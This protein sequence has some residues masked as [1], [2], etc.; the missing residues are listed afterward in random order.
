[1]KFCTHLR[2]LDLCHVRFI[3]TDFKNLGEIRGP[4]HY[5]RFDGF[6]VEALAERCIRLRELQI[7][8]MPCDGAEEMF[9]VLGPSLK[10]L[11]IEESLMTFDT[12]DANMIQTDGWKLRKV[13]IVLN[14]SEAPKLKSLLT[15]LGEQFR[16]ANVSELT[17]ELREEVMSKCPHVR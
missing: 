12:Y 4:L 15:S 7:T 14:G 16:F 9:R 5:L 10:S 11:S 17:D 2:S 13:D 1:M 8:T 6:A 3:A